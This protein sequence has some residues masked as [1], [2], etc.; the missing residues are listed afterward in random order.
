MELAHGQLKTLRPDLSDAGVYAATGLIA[1][2]GH[3]DQ[4]SELFT[5]DTFRTLLSYVQAHKLGRFSFWSLNRDRV[6]TGNVGWVDGKCSSV[7]Q[8]PYD[9]AKII[10][11]YQS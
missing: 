6:C 3:T 11:Q 2:N 1:M 4:P 5:V 8:Q 9:F 10:A 7:S